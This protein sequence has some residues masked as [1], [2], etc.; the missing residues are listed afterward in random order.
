MAA[1]ETGGGAK[2]ALGPRKAEALNRL[3]T[4][5][6]HLDGVVRMLEEDAYCVDLMK[7]ISAVQSSLERVNRLILRN[8]LETCF[9]EAVL[10]GRGPA[11]IEELL[12][13]VK[14]SPALTGPGSRMGGAATGEGR[15]ARSGRASGGRASGGGSSEGRR[16][17]A[18]RG[19][20]GGA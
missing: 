18:R 20:E 8:H 11:A 5:R 14:F 10:G 15:R 4:V 16:G 12:D 3:R 1:L 7:Q 9:T 19:S 13:A 6:G 17:G 2:A